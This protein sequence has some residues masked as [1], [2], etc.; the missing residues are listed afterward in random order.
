MQTRQTKKDFRFHAT[1]FCFTLPATLGDRGKTPYERLNKPED[2]TR[3][4]IELGF[5]D[6]PLKLCE[7]D[8]VITKRVREAIQRAGEALASGEP[9]NRKDL[10]EINAIAVELPPIPQLATD[11]RSIIWKIPGLRSVLSMISRD[12]I[13]LA[14][15]PLSGHVKVCENPECRGIFIDESRAQNRRWCSMQ[16]CGNQMKKLKIRKS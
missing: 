8:L 15:G 3:W 13:D 5:S 10:D 9:F 1:R 14:I 12:F 2:L 11:G 4:L 6:F 7:D 16:T